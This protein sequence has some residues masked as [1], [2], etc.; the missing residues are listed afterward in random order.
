MKRLKMLLCSFLLLMTTN[1]KA[2]TIADVATYHAVPGSSFTY[3]HTFS[4][5]SNISFSLPFA[6][7]MNVS[8][9][10]LSFTISYDDFVWFICKRK[11]ISHYSNEQYID[12]LISDQTSTGGWSSWEWDPVAKGYVLVHQTNDYTNLQYLI[13]TVIL[14]V[15]YYS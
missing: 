6:T 11:P 4:E 12:F 8:G 13:Q 1:I 7:S 15:Y 10:H 9:N 3:S 2:E 14:R 5:L